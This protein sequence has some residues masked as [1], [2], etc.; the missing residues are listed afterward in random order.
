[1]ESATKKQKTDEEPVTETSLR[2][3]SASSSSLANTEGRTSETPVAIPPTI[4]Y[5]FQETHTT[6]LPAI[7]WFSAPNLTLN[8]KPTTFSIRLNGIYGLFPD[9]P[10]PTGGD[11][12]KFKLN[13][14]WP[15]K[16]G[17]FQIA[18]DQTQGLPF[19][20]EST[21]ITPWYRD[22]WE[23]LYMY[24]TVLGCEYEIVASCPCIAGRKAL[25]AHSVQ[26]TGSNNNTSVSLPTDVALKELYGMKNIQFKEIAGRDNA[27]D[28]Y[29]N[30]QIIRGTF[31]PGSALR[32]VS[33]DGDVKLWSK[34]DATGSG[35]NPAYV[36]KLQIMSYVHPLSTAGTDDDHIENT[37]L[38]SGIH[39]NYQVRLKYIVQFKQ[40]RQTIRFP[41]T[42]ASTQVIQFPDAASPY[43]P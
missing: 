29:S 5:G 32:D 43:I 8:Y 1:M 13:Q 2:T 28:G 17:E 22:T 37:S 38:Q 18:I 30:V 20:D 12:G 21:N 24:Y 9:F 27:E 16:C 4:T 6:V 23:K 41:L 42:G 36:E 25:L 34:T 31:K 40:L 10:I 35:E 15:K 3:M 14:L 11:A 7:R 26:T 33:N 19:P 39:I